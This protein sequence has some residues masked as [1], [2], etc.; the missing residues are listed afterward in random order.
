MKKMKSIILFAT[1]LL[2]LVASCTPTQPDATTGREDD[3]M[4]ETRTQTI[5]DRFLSGELTDE[6]FAEVSEELTE[7]EMEQLFDKL[8]NQLG[9]EEFNRLI[10]RLLGEEV[11]RPLTEEEIEAQRILM[12]EHRRKNVEYIIRGDFTPA[13]DDIDLHTIERV[14]FVDSIDMEGGHGFVLDQMYGRVYYDPMT[15]FVDMLEFIPYSSE[16]RDEDLSRLIQVIEESD[17]RDWEEHYTGRIDEYAEG[18][19]RSWVIGLLFSDGTILRRSGSGMAYT[20]VASSPDQL[21]ILTDFI[22]TIGAEIELRH[23]AEVNSGN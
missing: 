8:R 1:I 5:I 2:L 17:L 22:K 3:N 20:D 4:T 19:G 23:E 16:F 15:S 14:V 9:D 7:E 11:N 6:E 13:A 21:A 10:S 18:G 12:E